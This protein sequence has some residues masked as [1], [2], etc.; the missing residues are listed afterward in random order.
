MNK[1]DSDLC[2]C[3]SLSICAACLAQTGCQ[4]TQT[5][6]ARGESKP[7]IL[8][9]TRTT[10]QT[11]GPRLSVRSISFLI[12]K[13]HVAKTGVSTDRGASSAA[14]GKTEPQH[15]ALQTRWT[16]L[17]VLGLAREVAHGLD[18]EVDTSAQGV[19]PNHGDRKER[20]RVV[21][22]VHDATSQ[23]PYLWYR[24]AAILPLGL[25]HERSECEAHARGGTC[26]LRFPVLHLYSIEAIVTRWVLAGEDGVVLQ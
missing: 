21:V 25:L 17:W 20:R 19:R 18:G 22:V 2:F 4:A 9:K 5:G 6:G 8:T 10:E 11:V 15:I 12:L 23:V 26:P 14:S 24:T 7:Q 1:L 16:H 13:K 3:R